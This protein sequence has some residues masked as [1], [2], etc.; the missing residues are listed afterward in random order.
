MEYGESDPTIV[1][2]GELERIEV[3]TFPEP[4]EEES[5]Q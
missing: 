3:E 2:L 1:Q 4:V 5:L